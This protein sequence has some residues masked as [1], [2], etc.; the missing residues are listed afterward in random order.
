MRVLLDT[1]ALLWYHLGDPKLSV[2]ARTV[3]DDPAH[4]KLVSAATHW[5]IAIKLSLGNG[6][7]RARRF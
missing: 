5:E 4:E 6:I 1:H 3:M 7:S 2:T